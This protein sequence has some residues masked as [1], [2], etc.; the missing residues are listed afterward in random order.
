MSTLAAL[1]LACSGPGAICANG[2]GMKLVD[3]GR[4]PAVLVDANENAAVRRAAAGLRGDLDRLA[5]PSHHPAPRLAVIVGTLGHNGTIDRLAAEHRIDVTGVRGR[6]EAYLQQVVDQPAPGLDRALVIVGSDRRG[7][8]FGAYDVSRRAGVSPWA[9]WADVPVPVRTQVT[10]APGARIDQPAVKYRGIFLNDEDPSL[11][12]WAKT[13]FGGVGINHRFYEREFD[14]I[15][16][17]KGNMIWPAMWGKSLWEDDPESAKVADEMGIVLGTSHHE[18]MLRAQADWHKANG[19]A[20]DYSKNGERLRAFW[21]DGIARMA[22][23]DALV[24]IGM[25]GDGDEPMTQGTAIP[26]LEHIV[27]DQRAI[28]ADVTKKPASETP[29]VWALYK[30]VQDYYDAGMKVPDDVTLLFSDDNWGN[31]RRLPAIGAT[32]RAGGYGIYY[33]FDYVG[34]PRNYKWLNVT[35][36]GRVW[37]QMSL[38][39]AHGA[40]R[41]WIANVGDLK[42]MELPISFFLDYAWKPESYGPDSGKT[43]V[44]AWAADQFGP[45]HAAGIAD[46]LD[47]ETRFAARRTPE[48]TAPET[49]DVATEWPRI[50]ADYDKLQA[51]AERVGRALPA[52]MQDAYL[53]LVLHPVLATAN[54]H[55][56]YYATAKARAYS[57]A[58][59][60]AADATRAFATDKAIKARYEAAAGGKWPHMMDQTHIGYT[61]WQQPD[62]DVMPA[63]SGPT[64]SHPVPA[65]YVAIDAV[66]AR[67]E[68]RGA[69]QWARVDGLGRIGA[70][71][72]ALPQ[73]TPP[74]APGAGPALAFDVTISGGGLRWLQLVA[75]PSIATVKDAHLR[76][77]VSVDDGAPTVVD[78]AADASDKAWEQSV[79]AH[80]RVGASQATLRAGRHV[81]RVWAIDPGVVAERLVVSAAPIDPLALDWP[82]RPTRGEQD[83]TRRRE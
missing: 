66:H 76:Y 58:G 78:L 33:H 1:A 14:L 72:T 5:G 22:G 59:D 79:I 13:T 63:L 47:R 71:M 35:Q 50:V 19:G 11:S 9:W 28:I 55:R 73:T 6:W 39:R 26:L 41:L 4:V 60:D 27:A 20:W 56:M 77:A 81:V 45:A 65:D 2:A 57:R 48:L 42:P 32:P 67:V 46:I 51:D 7:A 18:P 82:E 17:L 69:A 75:A 74:L 61:G 25:R 8:V 44:Q 24:T 37:E 21:R 83:T 12:G 53:E 36:I 23:R 64:A 38:A 34:G 43:Y 68:P 40:D 29:Q 31:I 80:A 49:W 70:A 3:H 30:E 16:R 62:V 10:V 15:L 54:L 52:A